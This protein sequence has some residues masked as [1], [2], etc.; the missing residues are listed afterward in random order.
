[1]ACSRRADPW[2]NPIEVNMPIFS[3]KVLVSYVADIPVCADTEADALAYAHSTDEWHEDGG[4]S[5]VDTDALTLSIQGAVKITDPKQTPW[6][7]N[8]GVWNDD[9]GTPLAGIFYE[10]PDPE[11][12]SEKQSEAYLDAYFDREREMIAKFDAARR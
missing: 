12:P 2:H 10:N 3:L 7:G 5:D 1:M 4:L 6:D 9:T 11:P 8:T